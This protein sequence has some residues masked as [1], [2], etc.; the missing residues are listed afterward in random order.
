MNG[1]NKP[2]NAP[3]P[4]D[5]FFNWI[6]DYYV[7]QKEQEQNETL[8]N[9]MGSDLSIQPINENINNIPSLESNN[10]TIPTIPNSYV[11]N[12]PANKT[13]TPGA[14]FITPREQKNV[15]ALYDPTEKGTDAVNP[16]YSFVMPKVTSIANNPEK[17]QLYSMLARLF[18]QPDYPGANPAQSRL[19]AFNYVSD[20]MVMKALG[21]RP[22]PARY[23]H[24][25]GNRAGSWSPGNKYVSINKDA[26]FQKEYSMVP[27]LEHEVTHTQTYDPNKSVE[28]LERIADRNWANRTNEMMNIVM[29]PPDF[30]YKVPYKNI[31]G[32]MK[33]ESR[34]RTS[35]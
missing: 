34:Y 22:F 28:E 29:P 8:Q 12:N 1:G 23:E 9:R 18:R 16:N 33:L 31:W 20:P 13:D 5:E 24:I 27:A 4:A 30:P 15:F 32:N 10:N 25:S 14:S 3:I 11:Y 26:P 35:Q 21:I 19:E 2:K 7:K 6:K 17:S